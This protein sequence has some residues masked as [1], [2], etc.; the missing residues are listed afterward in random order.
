MLAGDPRAIARG[1]SLIE[2]ET[3][4]GAA[5]IGRIF[6]KD[7]Q[8]AVQAVSEVVDEMGITQRGGRAA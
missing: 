6:P 3:A 7:L 1:I 4:A 2:D 8:G 5:L